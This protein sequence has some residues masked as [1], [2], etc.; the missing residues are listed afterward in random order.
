VI[1]ERLTGARRLDRQQKLDV[2]VMDVVAAS[3]WREA[4]RRS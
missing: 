4:A 1:G 2:V 3:Q